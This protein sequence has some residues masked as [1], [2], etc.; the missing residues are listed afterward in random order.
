MKNY[1]E[2]LFINEVLEL[3][4]EAGVGETYAKIYKKRVTESLSDQEIDFISQ[5]ES[6]YIS[7]ISSTGWPYI[8]HRGGP[9]GFLKVIDK[10]VLGFADY[11]GNKQFITMGHVARNKKVALFLMDYENSARLKIL[12]H[13][14]MVHAKDAD[15]SIYEKL[16]T[17]G[18]G[19]VERI[20]TINI[21]SLDWN[22]PKYI[23]QLINISKFEPQLRAVIKENQSLKEQL[24][25]LK[26]SI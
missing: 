26:K 25:K 3:Q 15:P 20:A 12:G 5:R 10:N 9:E 22:C 17:E 6:F 19:K 13:L 4:N 23:P 24:D 21:E 14:K 16:N 18:Q 11:T 1:A 7:S 2:L 8:Q